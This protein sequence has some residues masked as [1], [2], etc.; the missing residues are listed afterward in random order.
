[1]LER[2]DS[3]QSEKVNFLDIRLDLEKNTNKHNR[4]LGDEPL[5]VDSQE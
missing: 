4:K 3:P 5:Y 1:M 2:Y